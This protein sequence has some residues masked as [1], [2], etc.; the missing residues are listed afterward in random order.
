MST[1]TTNRSLAV[2]QIT[3]AIFAGTLFGYAAPR[4]GRGALAARVVGSALLVA[5]FAPALVRRLLRAGAARRRVH[6]HTTLELDR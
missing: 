3:E 5:A 4:R 2:E 6:L 1:S